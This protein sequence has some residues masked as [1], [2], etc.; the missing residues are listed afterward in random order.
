MIL[1]SGGADLS[2]KEAKEV[3]Q[4]VTSQLDKAARVIWGASVE[5]ELGDVLRV[6]II[7]TGVKSSEFFD[8]T[9]RMSFEAKKEIEEK[10]GIEFL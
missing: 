8:E 7:I 4:A 5:P 10:L 2:L 9:Q 1:V 6:M 3:V